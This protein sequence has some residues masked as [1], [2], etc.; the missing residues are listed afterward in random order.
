MH[1]IA[2]RGGVVVDGT[3]APARRGDIGITGGRVTAVGDVGPARQT[4][5]ADGQ[6]V[7]PGFVDVRVHVDEAGRNDLPVG[8]NGLASRSHVAHGR[9]APTGDAD[10]T[11]P[12]RRAGAVDDNPTTDRN[13]VHAD[14][15][16][17]RPRRH[18]VEYRTLSVSTT[19][20][21]DG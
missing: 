11:A 7:A 4:I 18:G 1:D 3:G 19:L 13:V 6:V 9:D 16:V 10:V 2:I 8:L 15:L 21:G 5:E 14:L 12:R 17:R 20:T